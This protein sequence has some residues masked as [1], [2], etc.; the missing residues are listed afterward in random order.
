LRNINLHSLVAV[1]SN[2]VGNVKFFNKAA[3]L[4][5]IDQTNQSFNCPVGT[6]GIG[7]A[8]A[9]GATM[10][11]YAGFG[12]TD[13][14]HAFGGPSN[15]LALDPDHGAAFPGINPLVGS[16]VAFMSGGRSVY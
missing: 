2:Q 6:A 12:L 15:A 9:A 5:A 10:G 11:D 16:N 7:C 8:I 13:A 14:T 4:N 1:D 3:A